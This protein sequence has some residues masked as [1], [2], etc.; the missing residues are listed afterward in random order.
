M[1]KSP[2]VRA[3]GEFLLLLLQYLQLLLQLLSFRDAMG[4]IAIDAR[5]CLGAA[6]VLLAAW[7]ISAI[8]TTDVF[9]VVMLNCQI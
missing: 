7:G 5:G 1:V 4:A 6:D 8:E 9:S 3:P 2:L